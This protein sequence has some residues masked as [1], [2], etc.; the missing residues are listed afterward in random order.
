MKIK[1]KKWKN[2]HFLMA[3]RFYIHESQKFKNPFHR[4]TIDFAYEADPTTLSRDI[5]AK[6]FTNIDFSI[7]QKTILP[8][9]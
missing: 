6:T 5:K 9:I 4:R 7:L 1:K 2:D 8:N 3:T